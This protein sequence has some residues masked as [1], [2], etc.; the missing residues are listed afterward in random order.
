VNFAQQ[1]QKNFLSQIFC[2]GRVPYH[3]QAYLIHTSAMQTIEVFKRYP[4]AVPGLLDGI[5][6][7]ELIAGDG[8]DWRRSLLRDAFRAGTGIRILA[9]P[10]PYRGPCQGWNHRPY[11]AGVCSDLH[12]FF[13]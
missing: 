13:P 11:A 6:F 1:E 4:I 5:R 2:L 9:T 8:R 12:D 10:L 7:R 3:A